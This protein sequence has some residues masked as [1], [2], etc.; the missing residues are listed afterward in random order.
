[1]QEDAG[2]DLRQELVVAQA[3]HA[4]VQLV[5]HKVVLEDV[6]QE[7]HVAPGLGGAVHPTGPLNP[8]QLGV[9]KVVETIRD[10]YLF[11]AV[12]AEVS[13]FNRGKC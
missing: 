13:I 8:G 9:E 1:M 12:R 10:Y 3:G 4:G 7:A 2:L 11:S 6:H 5:R